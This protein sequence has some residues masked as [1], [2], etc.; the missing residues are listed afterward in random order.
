MN[1]EQSPITIRLDGTNPGHFFACCGLF[2]LSHRLWSGAQGWFSEVADEF[3][4][5]PTSPSRTFDEQGLLSAIAACTVDNSMTAEQLKRRED[6]ASRAKEVKGTP[7]LELEKKRLDSLWRESAVVLGAPFPL[8]V[9]WF[10]DGRAGGSIFK[11]WAGQQSVIDIARGMH[12]ALMEPGWGTL[13]ASDW[14]LRAAQLDA[15]PFNFDSSLGA[16]GS[17]RDVGFSFDPLKDM[18]VLARPFAEFCAFVGLQRFRPVR[19][20]KENRFQ[21]AAWTSPMTPDVAAAA[22]CGIVGSATSRPFEFR[23]LYR[24]KYLKSFLPA[25]PAKR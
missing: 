11:T 3:F 7:A 12:Q 6:L 23:L 18:R 17:D 8:R 1:R 15:L 25:S 16:L 21:Y 22:A 4:L 19:M 5:A 14:L 9:D 2:E 13:P 24:T 10:T 20:G